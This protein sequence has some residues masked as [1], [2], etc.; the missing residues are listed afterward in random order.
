M[1]RSYIST[2]DVSYGRFGYSSSD[3]FAESQFSFSLKRRSE[4]FL[5]CT[6][7]RA[8]Y[9]S[10]RP[11]AKGSMRRSRAF[12][13]NF[14]LSAKV[15]EVDYLI[16]TVVNAGGHHDGGWTPVRNG[17]MRSHVV[18][19][20]IYFLYVLVCVAMWLWRPYQ[21][22]RF[23]VQITSMIE[24]I[25]HS[26]PCNF[27]WSH[28]AFN[29]FILRDETMWLSCWWVLQ[30]FYHLSQN[31]AMPPID[32][33]WCICRKYCKGKRCLLH[34][35]NTWNCH[36]REAAEDEIESIKLTRRSDVFHAF[37]SSGAGAS[38]SSTQKRSGDEVPSAAGLPK[39]PRTQDI[40]DLTNVW[41][42][43]TRQPQGPQALQMQQTFVWNQA[44]PF[45][46]QT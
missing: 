14:L 13:A 10:C 17:H 44:G 36:L 4:L 43:W 37:L 29:R 42:V 25:W 3:L 23:H 28:H 31:T 5:C 15:S 39:C 6:C 46:G 12:F 35:T 20:S 7:D 41:R 22:I 32:Q 11:W 2:S 8:V 24:S 30:W 38:S 9:T 26:S 1:T 34:S 40:S 45:L 33:L 18:V 27:V 21:H 19:W 16:P